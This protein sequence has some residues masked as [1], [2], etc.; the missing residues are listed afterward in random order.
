MLIQNYPVRKKSREALDAQR[1]ECDSYST[2]PEDDRK[3]WV[4]EDMT[5]TARA[6]KKYRHS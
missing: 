6:L 5:L 1:I 2:M 4:S 3:E